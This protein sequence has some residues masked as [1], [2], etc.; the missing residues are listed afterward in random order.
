MSSAEEESVKRQAYKVQSRP[1]VRRRN[2]N[3]SSSSSSAG[4]QLPPAPNVPSN[5]LPQTL[6]HGMSEET[7]RLKLKQLSE[8]FGDHEHMKNSQETGRPVCAH[9]ALKSDLSHRPV[10]EEEDEKEEKKQKPTKEEQV[11]Q[12]IREAIRSLSALATSPTEVEAMHTKQLDIK[13]W[14]SEA[15]AEDLRNVPLPDYYLENDNSRSVTSTIVQ[16]QLR[17]GRFDLLVQTAQHECELLKEAGQFRH[18][19]GR[20]YQF[21]ACVNG[22]ECVA[23]KGDLLITGL[24]QPIVLMGFMF[25]SEYTE[26]LHSS[27]APKGIRPCVLCCRCHLVRLTMTFRGI[28]MRGGDGLLVKDGAENERRV[29]QILQCYRNLEDAEGGYF[30]EYMLHPQLNEPMIDP[31]VR[32]NKLRLRANK[33]EHGRWCIDQSALIYTKPVVPEHRMGESLQSF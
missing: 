2:K 14:E 1:E 9:A 15:F 17:N 6:S 24:S 19:N 16:Q 8:I 33:D 27:K 25:E 31:I 28:V 18:S 26:F 22:K 7:V 3:S 29:T 20:V 23:G 21:P 4:L 12:D 10:K 32:M 11:Q 5:P 13:I 30:R